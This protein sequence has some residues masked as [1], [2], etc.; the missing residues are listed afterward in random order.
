MNRLTRLESD[1]RAS[2]RATD[3]TGSRLG[4]RMRRRPAGGPSTP[5]TRMGSSSSA[6]ARGTRTPSTNTAV[7]CPKTYVAISDS[8]TWSFRNSTMVDLRWTVSGSAVRATSLANAQNATT[9]PRHFRFMTRSSHARHT[10]PRPALRDKGVFSRTFLM[11]P[12]VFRCNLR[13]RPGR[14][15]HSPMR[16]NLSHFQPAGDSPPYPS[17]LPA[18][19]PESDSPCRR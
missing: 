19:H 10:C 4:R 14:S 18:L 11:V 9:M 15:E 6:A 1:T 3:A 12:V 2:G 13:H 16:S 17:R 7:S 8:T 5:S